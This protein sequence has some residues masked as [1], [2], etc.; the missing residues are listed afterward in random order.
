MLELE[1]VPFPSSYYVVELQ[2]VNPLNRRT[3]WTTF[4]IDRLRQEEI[5]W[6]ITHEHPLAYS[7]VDPAFK[8]E[9]EREAVLVRRFN[10]FSGRAESPVYDPVDAYYVPLAGYAG[11][12]RPGP[13]IQIYRLSP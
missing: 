4:D 5:E 9:L 1:G 6:V 2:A 3:V 10:P 7:Q 13:S 11:V 12:E 8:E